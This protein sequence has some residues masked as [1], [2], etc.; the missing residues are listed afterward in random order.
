[1]PNTTD[2]YFVL[3]NPSSWNSL[4]ESDIL[5]VLKDIQAAISNPDSPLII[6]IFNSAADFILFCS[7]IKL[8]TLDMSEYLKDLLAAAL[9]KLLS[10]T[11][12]DI[13]TTE[14]FSNFLKLL[15]KFIDWEVYTPQFSEIV[16]KI[17]ASNVNAPA[18]N[19]LVS[20]YIRLL[21]KAINST[22]GDEIF[23]KNLLR[24]ISTLIEE[25]IKSKDCTDE[26]KNE[27]H[28]TFEAVNITS[29]S[30][31]ITTTRLP[32]TNGNTTKQLTIDAGHSGNIT[33]LT[34]QDATPT[35]ISA[36]SFIP[37][38]SAAVEAGVIAGCLELPSDVLL[39]IAIRKGCS[40]PILNRIRFVLTFTTSFAKATLPLLYSLLLN[41]LDDETDPLTISQKIT[42]TTTIFVLNV[43]LQ[44]IAYYS[45]TRLN[46]DSIL[47][48][49]VKFLPLLAVIG[50][51]VNV[52][53]GL[54]ATLEKIQEALI[55][56]GASF[57]GAAIPKTLVNIFTFFCTPANNEKNT[58]SSSY[59]SYK[60][61][62]EL[63]PLSTDSA[64]NSS[65]SNRSSN[66]SIEKQIYF[67]K[68]EKLK[69]ITKWLNSVLTNLTDL[70]SYFKVI[71]EAMIAVK[72]G[73]NYIVFD[74]LM[75]KNNLKI[76]LI[77]E[78]ENHLKPHIEL[79]NDNH[80]T[81]CIPF[82]NPS[83]LLANTSVTGLH[84]LLK[85]IKEKLNTVNSN[86]D[87]IDGVESYP[88]GTQRQLAETRR[89]LKSILDFIEVIFKNFDSN[90]QGVNAAKALSIS[91]YF[92]TDSA[93]RKSVPEITFREKN[94]IIKVV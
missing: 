50:M 69:E 42:S 77:Q 72:E 87:K 71:N 49:A 75:E 86:L 1:M 14:F 20:Q 47:K 37:K 70:A 76:K 22:D 11:T 31:P 81:A 56:F 80:K 44:G 33:E 30:T 53:E 17:M 89:Y 73:M 16:K 88:P 19:A 79:L 67:I 48:L 2:M 18:K 78:S 51:V 46:K 9:N 74:D 7:H 63:F 3:K 83:E 4:K 41:D 65:Q 55:L 92:K 43:I 61:T 10:L 21:N 32:T 91:Q 90:Q 35:T 68:E 52:E 66:T 38:I 15:D 62:Q 36:P 85:A 94:T 23:Q 28:T 13:H 29:T 64:S 24:A 54:D 12:F 82:N 39:H 25:C 57:L 45:E 26:V 6:N 27:L 40:E 59:E 84:A 93:R 8:Q 60:E 34:L 58:L 5:T